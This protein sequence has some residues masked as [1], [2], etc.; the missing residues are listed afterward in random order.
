MKPIIMLLI[1]T[2]AMSAT[3][4]QKKDT[5]SNPKTD[6]TTQVTY[7]CEMHPE[8]VSSE[9]GKCSKCGMA[10]NL[11]KKEQMKMEVMKIYTCS[12]HPEVKSDKPGKCPKCDMDL[13][14][15]K[16]KKKAKKS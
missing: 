8:V 9:P 2:F 3:F 6:T 15:V 5:S 1:A 7:T 16:T 11:S 12:M 14:E 10:L 13:T 4:A